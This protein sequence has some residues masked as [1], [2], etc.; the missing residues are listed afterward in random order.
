V[1]AGMPVV[2]AAAVPVDAVAALANL[3]VVGATSSGF[4]T[5]DTCAVL[6]SSDPVHSNVN[7][8][9][10]D[11]AVTNLGIVPTMSSDLGAQFC[12]ESPTQQ[13]V[14]VDV[15]GVFAPA[16][17]GG[18]GYTSLAPSRLVDTRKCW[19]DPVTT[20]QRCAAINAAGSV[21]RMR[22]PAGASQVLV[23]LTTTAGQAIG[24]VA[25]DK[26]SVIEAGDHVKG[27][28][29]IVPGAAVANLTVVPVDADGTF[30]AWV[31]S[32]THLVVDQ[33][34]TFSA[35]GGLRFLPITPT[36]LLDSR[37]PAT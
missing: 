4:L 11:R 30:C 7:F 36:R 24:Y 21:V 12:T 31:S 26:C 10:G 19:T 15:L 16:A 3:T 27:S 28:V 2:S 5:A 13:G 29:Q 22:A 32:T 34:G 6:T 14:V 17:Q 8:V 1:P 33:F 37:Q 9:A 18:L 23:N 20:T 25:A 35:A